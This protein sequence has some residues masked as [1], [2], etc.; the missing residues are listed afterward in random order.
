MTTTYLGKE[1]DKRIGSR[2]PRIGIEALG[3][4]NCYERSSHHLLANACRF[5]SSALANSLQWEEVEIGK[6]G[7]LNQ[8]STQFKILKASWR[9]TESAKDKA[10]PPAVQDQCKVQGFN[11]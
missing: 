8:N 7:K 9:E 11:F 6:D 3:V 10:A 1:H 4:E 2:I 5:P